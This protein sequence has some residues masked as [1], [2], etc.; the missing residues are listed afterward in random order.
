MRFLYGNSSLEGINFSLEGEQKNAVQE[1]YDNEGKGLSA[2]EFY[3]LVLKS[4]ISQRLVGLTRQKK[5]KIML[6]LCLL[7][8]VR[9]A[10]ST[11]R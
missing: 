2:H 8:A 6:P 5:G 9:P 7:S 11:T 10:L 3:R 4:I 1:P